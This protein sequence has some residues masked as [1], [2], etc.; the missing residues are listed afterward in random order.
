MI[1][2]M[3]LFVWDFHGVLEQ[4]AELALIET[5]NVILEKFGYQ[6]RFTI[7]LLNA[8]YGLKW[9]E[10]F[11]RLLPDLSHQQ[12]LDLQNACIEYAR[13]DF[14]NTAKHILPTKYAA[15]VLGQIKQAGHD[16]IIISNVHADDLSWFLKTVGLSKYF[17]ADKRLVLSVYQAKQ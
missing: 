1:R 5:S 13:N 2:P 12:C 4:N 3:K 9:Y 14:S 10:L 17:S 11:E 16:Q 6:Q 8:F 15:E 7:E